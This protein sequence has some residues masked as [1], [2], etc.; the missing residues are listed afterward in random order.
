MLAYEEDRSA[1]AAT[2]LTAIREQPSRPQAV[3]MPG[4]TKIPYFGTFAEMTKPEG[5]DED[6]IEE[7]DWEDEEEER[8][9]VTG[10]EEDNFPRWMDRSRA[11]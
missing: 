10:P 5:E 7:E 4:T 11:C 9:D 6:G 3:E 8:K 1:A 2:D